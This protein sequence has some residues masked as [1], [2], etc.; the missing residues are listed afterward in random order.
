[1]KVHEAKEELPDLP[2][3]LKLRIHFNDISHK[4]TTTFLSLIDTARILPNSINHVL[5]HLYKPCKDPHI[6]P[7]RSVTLVLRDMGGVAYTT[8]LDIDE[9]HKE[10]HF[11]LQHIQNVSGEPLRCRDEIIGVITHEMV[12]TLQWNCYGTAPGG[13]VEGLAD[14]VRL[15]AGLAPP[16]WKGAKHEVGEKWDAGYQ[17][18]AYF[19]D[20]LETIHGPGIIANMNQSMRDC[21]YEEEGFWTN[22]FGKE[23]TVETLWKNYRDSFK[24]DSSSTSSRDSEPIMVEK[25]DVEDQQPTKGA[26]QVEK[27]PVDPVSTKV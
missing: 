26:N 19:L 9:L 27:T 2:L 15:R 10:I 5:R 3:T 25:S 16:H 4:S 18:T 6:P 23:N 1:M 11:S 20:W 21:K 17:K 8:G 12:H 7:I 22:L 13:L 24:D 14:Y